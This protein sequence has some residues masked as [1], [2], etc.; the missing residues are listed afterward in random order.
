MSTLTQLDF[1]NRMNRKRVLARL[2]AWCRQAGWD[3]MA[4]ARATN[5]PI[6]SCYGWLDGTIG[7][8]TIVNAKAIATA[9]D[10]IENGKINRID[11]WCRQEELDLTPVTEPEQSELEKTQSELKAV[12]KLHNELAYLLEIYRS[13]VKI[14]EAEILLNGYRQGRFQ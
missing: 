14:N 9:V 13:K 2:K 11:G 12:C 8:P 4:L 5:L 6:S 7:A 3:A 10:A 1:E